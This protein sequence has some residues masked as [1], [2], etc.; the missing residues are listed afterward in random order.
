MVLAL[1]LDILKKKSGPISYADLAEA[2]EVRYGEPVQFN[3][4]K[5]GNP[6]GAAADAAI[7]V[8]DQHGLLVPPLSLIVVNANTGLPGRGAD[9]FVPRLRGKNLPIN[10]AKRRTIVQEEVEHVWSF[11][12]R[13]WT[14]LEGLLGLCPYQN[15]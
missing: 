1:L 13:N 10:G 11:G 9:Q 3:K 5:Y 14:K 7:F 6:L 12:T 8:G 2:L 4:Q 15:Q